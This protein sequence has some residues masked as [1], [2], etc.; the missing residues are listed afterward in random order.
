MLDQFAIGTYGVLAAEAM[1]AGRVVV[2]HVPDQVRRM[3][4][5]EPPIVEATPDDLE[6]VV[7]RL[8]TDRDA[9]RDVA[10]KGVPYVREL[11]DGRFS[12]AVLRDVLGLRGS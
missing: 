6:T 8:L 2:S 12:A 7:R 3:H 1:A 4:G 10:R 5:D 11:H 9:A